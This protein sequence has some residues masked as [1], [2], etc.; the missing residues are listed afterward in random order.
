FDLAVN[1]LINYVPTQYL[2]HGAAF[3]S[4]TQTFLNAMVANPFRGLIPSSATYNAPTIQRRLLLVP[5]PEFGNIAVTE[6]NGSSTYK[7]LQ[8]QLTKRYTQG[9]SLNASY[10]YSKERESLTRLNPQDAE[11]TEQVAANDRPHRLTFSFIY[12][13]PIGRNRWIGRNWN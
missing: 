13:L 2:N 4:S 8:L 1:R 9:L 10:T 7:A 11:L 5:Y 12:E 6:Y 3:D